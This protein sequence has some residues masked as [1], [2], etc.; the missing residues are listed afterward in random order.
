MS[1]LHLCLDINSY[2]HRFS[3][4]FNVLLS[5]FQLN[6]RDKY[7]IGAHILLKFASL[8]SI[9]FLRPFI[10]TSSH[11]YMY[12]VR[13]KNIFMVL[14]TSN[15]STI[16]NLWQLFFTSLQHIHAIWSHTFVYHWFNARLSALSASNHCLNQSWLIV[17]SPKDQSHEYQ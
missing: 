17:G 12:K 4:D 2:F 10:W 16:D 7:E 13:P 1:Q 14:V 5:L 6:F 15:K 9:C 11:W 3:T 8:D